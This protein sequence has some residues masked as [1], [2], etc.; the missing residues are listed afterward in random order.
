[1]PPNARITKGIRRWDLR[2]FACRLRSRLTGRCS[3]RRP[4]CEAEAVSSAL[5]STVRRQEL[6]HE[7]YDIDP[8][9]IQDDGKGDEEDGVDRIGDHGGADGLCRRAAQSFFPDRR[10]RLGHSDIAEN[11]E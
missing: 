6:L 11:R 9:Q 7:A 5:P 3:S 2:A 1:M 8:G 10:R 4:H